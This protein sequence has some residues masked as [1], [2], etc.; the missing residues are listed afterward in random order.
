MPSKQHISA[1]SVLAIAVK[2]SNRDIFKLLLLLG[3][4][5]SILE[6]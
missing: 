1:T 6:A 5:K 2:S 4:L 3:M